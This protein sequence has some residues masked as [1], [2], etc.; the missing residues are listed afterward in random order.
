MHA[1]VSDLDGPPQ[2][3]GE[4]VK[5]SLD[6]HGP[7]LQITLHEVHKGLLHQQIGLIAKGKNPELKLRKTGSQRKS[8]TTVN[9]KHG[10]SNLAWLRLLNNLSSA[11][12]QHSN[13]QGS[14]CKWGLLTPL[15][16]V[17]TH[18]TNKRQVETVL[19]TDTAATLFS[20]A[21]GHIRIQYHTW[22]IHKLPV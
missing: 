10:S 2:H 16:S 7:G 4:E 21:R 17:R 11:R 14:S 18:Q 13:A 3:N 6:K 20:S 5:G 1:F 12:L 19:A 15:L 9:I 8:V 22:E